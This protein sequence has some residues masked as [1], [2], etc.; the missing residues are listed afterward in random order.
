MIPLEP[1]GNNETVS[2]TTAAPAEDQSH[3]EEVLPDFS[4]NITDDNNETFVQRSRDISVAKDGKEEM[5]FLGFIV[6]TGL[7]P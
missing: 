1:P 2:T 4:V 5:S 3:H 7:K 6:N